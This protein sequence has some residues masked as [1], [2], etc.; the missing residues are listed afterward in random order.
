VSST[1]TH[2][3]CP[4]WCQRQDDSQ[5]LSGFDDSEWLDWRTGRTHRGGSGGPQSSGAVGWKYLGLRGR[6][7]CYGR[8]RGGRL[9]P[10]PSRQHVTAQVI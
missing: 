10:L 8:D 6:H 2:A 4:A 9:S 3:T 5:H 7:H 1:L